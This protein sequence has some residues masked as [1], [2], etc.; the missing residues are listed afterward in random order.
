MQKILF[1]CLFFPIRL[2]KYYQELHQV[3]WCILLYGQ[4]CLNMSLKSPLPSF[5][6]SEDSSE[7]I[8]IWSYKRDAAASP[9]RTLWRLMTVHPTSIN[10]KSLKNVIFQ[11]LFFF[12]VSR[13]YTMYQ[14]SIHS[15]S[16]RWPEQNEYLF[17][18]LDELSGDQVEN[19]PIET[20]SGHLW[21]IL[22]QLDFH[23]LLSLIRS[24][25]TFLIK[26]IFLYRPA[27]IFLL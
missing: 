21:D 10:L 26:S 27:L 6:P 15:S 8:I 23:F 13:A 19:V 12:K 4:Q 25:P 9:K 22:N 2:A 1:L 18:I 14:N 7:T 17:S 3:V 24:R 16:Q 5:S 11:L 20:F